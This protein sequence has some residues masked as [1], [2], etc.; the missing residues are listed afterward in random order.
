[1]DNRR[2]TFLAMVGTGTALAAF[3]V[4]RFGLGGS[5]GTLARARARGVIRIG[6][7]IEAP[8]AFVTAAGEVTGESPEMARRVVAAMGIERIQWRQTEFG[9]LLDELEAGRFDLV[10]AGT[11]VTPFRTERVAFSSPTLR[12]RP[13][14]LVRR[15]NPKKL[16]SYYDLLQA[17]DAVVAVLGGSVEERFLMDHRLPEKQLL[18]VPDALS[19]RVAVGNGRAAVLALSEPALRW[20][21]AH[22]ELHGLEVVRVIPG[23]ANHGGPGGPGGRGGRAR[24]GLGDGLSA[25]AFRRQDADLRQAFDA[26]LVPMIGGE[27]HRQLL[28]R[29]GLSEDELPDP[30][31]A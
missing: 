13:G 19:G 18:I 15:G 6:Y 28:R 30:K 5:P 25:F 9:A 22:Q 2:R 26:V 14:L 7:A 8:Y 17:T 1:M 11:F 21:A 23:P 10:A 20:M 24:L 29:F 3:G 12:V 4:V 27:A 31:V 16:Q